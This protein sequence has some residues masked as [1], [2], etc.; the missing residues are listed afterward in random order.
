MVVLDQVT[1]PQNVGAILRSAAAFG[2]AAVVL[3]ERNAAPESGALAKAASGALEAVPLVRVIQPARALEL[4]QAGFWRVGLEAGANQT[5]GTAP[6]DGRAALVMGAEGTGPEAPHAGALRPS[7]APA[8]AGERGGQ[9][10]RL[11][12]RGHRA[13]RGNRRQN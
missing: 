1:D 4:R 6:L 12:G 8:H 7:G 13:L 9:P 2:A 11:R 5:I 10:E 3:P